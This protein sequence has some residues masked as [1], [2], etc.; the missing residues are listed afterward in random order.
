VYTLTPNSD[1]IVENE[2]PMMDRET[3]VIG[4]E[5]LAEDAAWKAEKDTEVHGNLTIERVVA[6]RSSVKH[7]VLYEEQ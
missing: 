4:K 2:D 3:T 5:P 7:K 1:F 6:T